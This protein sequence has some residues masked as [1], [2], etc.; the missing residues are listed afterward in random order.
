MLTAL[1]LLTRVVLLLGE[2]DDARALLSEATDLLETMPEGASQAKA[3]LAEIERR[4][5]DAQYSGVA[6]RLTD[7]EEA[8]LRLLQGSLPLRDV[9]AQLFV[10]VNT[11]KSHTRL[12][13]RKLGVSSRNEAIRR[14]RELGLL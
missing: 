13:Y 2:R 7:R 1:V 8:V 14:A 9:A 6:P 11:V 3:A 4:L 5:T 12:I 10:T